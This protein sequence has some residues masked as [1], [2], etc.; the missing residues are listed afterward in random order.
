M[1]ICRFEVVFEC[2]CT[3]DLGICILEEWVE[4]RLTAASAGDSNKMATQFGRKLACELIF[5]HFGESV[6]KVCKSLVYH[7]QLSLPEIAHYTKMSTIQI[8]N[9][10][11]VLVQHSCVQAFKVEHGGNIVCIFSNLKFYF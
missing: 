4:D 2:L 1:C 9:S 7:G 8:H 6:Q 11:L 3:K 10:L 5:S